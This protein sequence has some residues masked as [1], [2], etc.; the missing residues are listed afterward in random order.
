MRTVPTMSTNGNFAAMNN[1]HHDAMDSLIL[2]RCLVEALCIETY[3]D[4]STNQGIVGHAGHI[5]DNNDGDSFIEII[6]E[7]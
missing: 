2:N 1:A 6:A 5:R 3:S 7:L 4:M